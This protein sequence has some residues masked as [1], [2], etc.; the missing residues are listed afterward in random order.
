MGKL[1]GVRYTSKAVLEQ[2][3]GKNTAQVPTGFRGRVWSEGFSPHKI[4]VYQDEMTPLTFAHTPALG[5]LRREARQQ[6][7]VQAWIEAQGRRAD[8]LLQTGHLLHS[9]HSSRKGLKFKEEI[10][11]LPDADGLLLRSQ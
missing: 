4:S 5:R 6:I 9:F 10:L 11:R 1:Q 7:K 3:S 8:L 2:I